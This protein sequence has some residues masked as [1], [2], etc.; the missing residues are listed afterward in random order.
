MP[1]F[2]SFS[3]VCSLVAYYGNRYTTIAAKSSFEMTLCLSLIMFF[4]KC[5]IYISKHPALYE[6]FGKL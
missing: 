1:Y 2:H 6:F 5:D 4:T 3:S